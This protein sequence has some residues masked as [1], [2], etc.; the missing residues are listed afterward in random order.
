MRYSRCQTFPELAA[1][2]YTEI[3]GVREDVG[4]VRSLRYVEDHLGIT[5]RVLRPAR[6]DV[7]A[8]RIVVRVKGLDEAQE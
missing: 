1:G 5:R 3:C 6:C 2:E 8:H 4:R 7:V